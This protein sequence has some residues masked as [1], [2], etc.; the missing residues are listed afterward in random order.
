MPKETIRLLE[1]LRS[2]GF[3]DDDFRIV[4]HQ[5]A[6][7]IRSMT[8]YCERIGAF[9]AND[10]ND[11]VRERLRLVLSQYKNRGP[12]GSAAP[13]VFAA[14]AREAVEEI[15]LD[16]GVL[17]AGKMS[18][19]AYEELFRQLGF[20]HVEKRKTLKH[21]EL[22][23]SIYFNRTI[24]DEVY[25]TGYLRDES[26]YSDELWQFLLAKQKK[27]DRAQLITLV[28]IAGKEREAFLSLLGDFRGDTSAIDDLVEQE[29][30]QRTDIGPTDVDKMV[31]ARR[32]QGAY[33]LNL[34]QIE[35]RCRVTGIDDCRMLRASHIKPW[36]DSSDREK[37]DGFN[38]LLLSPHIDHLFDQG[39]ISF[40]D[41][42]DL[43]VAD[44]ID[45]SV[46]QAWGVGLDINVGLF[47]P[48]QCKYLEYHRQSVFRGEIDSRR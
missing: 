40:S 22:S 33:R 26:L 30:L 28:P 38:G 37:L 35:R 8:N 46:L 34:F 3:T 14:F 10:A 43:L 9:R 27:D 47:K 16:G 25:F 32:G 6:A 15:P 4:H 12:A 36:R 45:S 5:R 18:G 23:S 17:P 41:A 20:H 13:G 21:P 48:E 29:L 24:D 11:R 7:T 2:L 19:R 1:E 39:Y 44:D 31:R 42:G